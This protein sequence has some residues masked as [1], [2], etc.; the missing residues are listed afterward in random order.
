MFGSDYGAIYSDKEHVRE[1]C[2]IRQLT[3]FA[4]LKRGVETTVQ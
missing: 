2:T 3:R 4:D 1:S